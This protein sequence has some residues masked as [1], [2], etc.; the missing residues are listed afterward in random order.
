MLSTRL[1]AAVA[2]FLEWCRKNRSPATERA[3]SHQLAQAVKHFG[4]IDVADLT[5]ASVSNWSRSFHRIQAVQRLCSWMHRCEK[6][7]PDNPLRGMPKPVCGERRRTLTRTEIA[8]MMRASDRPFRDVLLVLRETLCRPQEARALRWDALASDRT[9]ATGAGA[10]G[11]PDAHFALG[12]GKGYDRRRERRS[13]RNIVLSPRVR[14]LLR[15]LAAKPRGGGGFVLVNS[16]GKPWT[17]EAI[18]NRIRRLRERTG[19]AAD[20]RG[21]KVVAYSFRHTGAT[22]AV[23]MGIRDFLL[24][25]TLG[26]ASTRTTARYVHL[27]PADLT[28]A[29]FRVWEVKNGR[30]GKK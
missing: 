5:P 22:N 25:E 21:E 1:S 12:D 16:R 27:K 9:D 11:E 8:R 23:R 3:Y 13:G 6:S 15:R 30:T 26:H 2:R 24:A 29:M 7:L 10:L 14:R 18:R 4:E 17:K 28:E 19:I 20:R